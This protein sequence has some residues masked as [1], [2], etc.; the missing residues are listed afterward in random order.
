[1]KKQLLFWVGS[2]F[3]SFG[4]GGAAPE[5]KTPTEQCAAG[6]TLVCENLCRSKTSLDACVPAGLAYINGAKVAPDAARGQE[7]LE[8]ACG[9][10]NAAACGQLGEMLLAGKLANKDPV[11]ASVKLRQ[12][13]F[14]HHAPSCTSLGIMTK[15]GK[16]I[17][18]D[19]K[20]GTELLR[21]ACSSGEARACY[22]VAENY[23]Y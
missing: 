6:D 7:L 1:M 17:A 23:L 8:L 15:Y 12:A 10:E 21:N 11:E 5:A 4:C 16:G 14:G 3:L 22:E 19:V 20:R 18:C 2:L 9:Q 13:C